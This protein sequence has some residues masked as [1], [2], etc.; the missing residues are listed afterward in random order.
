MASLLGPL[1]L[2]LCS[3]RR[4][5]IGSMGRAGMQT[6]MT[7]TTAWL[8]ATH[9]QWLAGLSVRFGRRGR[10]GPAKQGSPATYAANA[11]SEV[12]AV[13]AAC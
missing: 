7:F 11:K 2:K 12:R 13:G 8:A 5:S 4:D 10:L 9:G 1:A 6:S 3:S